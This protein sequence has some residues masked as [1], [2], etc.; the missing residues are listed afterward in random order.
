MRV[1]SVDFETLYD[2]KMGYDIK[3]LGAWKY[4][5]DA[6][7]DP[8][9][10]SVSD[11][12][13]TWAGSPSDFNWDSLGGAT[14]VSH[15]AAFDRTVYEAMMRK[16]MAPAVN[17]KDWQCSANLSAFLANRRSLKDAAAFLLGMSLSKETRNAADGKT[18]EDLIKAGKVEEMLAYARSDAYTCHR[19]YTKYQHLWPNREKAL[20]NLTIH[21]GMRGI[22]IDVPLLKEYINVA[23][24]MLQIAEASLPWVKE[25][26]S[27]T[28]PK[29]IAEHCRL[30]GIPCP[31][32]KS[33]FDNGQERFDEWEAAYGVK[34]KWIANVSNWRQINKF[35]ASLHTIRERLEDNGIFHFGLKYFG[36]HTGRWSGDAGFNMQNLRKDPLYRDENG[37]LI[38]DS[39]RLKEVSNSK[40]LPGYVTAVLDIRKLFIPRRGKKMIVSDLSQI[41][42]RV[43][44]WIVG[45]E[46]MLNLMRAG[47]SPYQA[48]AEATM[49]WTRGDMKE[50]IKQGDREA[51]DLYALAKARVLGLGYGCGWKKF[52][53]VAQAMAGLDIT[54]NDPEGPEGLVYVYDKNGNPR[55]DE[56]GGMIVEKA[57]GYVSR[58]TVEEYREQNPLIAGRDKI[59]PGIWKRLDEAFKASEGGTFEM[60][61]PSGRVMRYPGVRRECRQIRDED[62]GEIQRRWVTTAMIG[63]RR[64]PL[65]GGLLTENLVQA[66]ARDVF[67]EHCLN[68][69][70]T[71][72]IDVLFTSHDEAITEVDEH[73]TVRDIRETMSKPP[74]WMPGLP[75]DAEAKEVPHYVK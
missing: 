39:G 17:F 26:K 69:Q 2:T 30:A 51:K 31:P 42:P 68:L 41:E 47:R 10:I 54:A 29:A 56:K 60:T 15:N 1:V 28:S 73:I 48:H 45:D 18:W 46:A 72:G 8:Y 23:T 38:T 49:G 37:Y 52:I 64:F 7:F 63:D 27:P 35:L 34:H 57:H 65:Y 70:D 40:Q 14:L 24:E 19:L 67:G 58:R 33:H 9:L 21:Q 3:S 75:V 36:A 4:C 20:S 12:V 74:E 62:T 25:G 61:L 6:R 59:S 50:L 43:L 53:T 22:Q 55:L 71:S 32:V 44:A 66:T 16:G 13:E 11:G 5:D